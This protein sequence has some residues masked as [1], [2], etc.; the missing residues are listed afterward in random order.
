M[1]GFLKFQRVSFLDRF[2]K[3]RTHLLILIIDF[4]K[5]KPVET[6]RP[7]RNP[8]SCKIQYP[9]KNQDKDAGLNL[10]IKVFLGNFFIVEH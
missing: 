1:S 3:A 5:G 6:K 8:A 4:T 7:D 9:M 2:S 10:N